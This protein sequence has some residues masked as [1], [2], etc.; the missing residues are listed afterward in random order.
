MRLVAVEDAVLNVADE[1]PL[2]NFAKLRIAFR[3]ITF[4]YTI[5]WLVVLSTQSFYLDCLPADDD[6]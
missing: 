4:L 2:P 1:M 3:S 6:S 5:S